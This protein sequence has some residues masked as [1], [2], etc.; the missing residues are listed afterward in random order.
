MMVLTAKETDDCGAIPGI[1]NSSPL[2]S[3]NKLKGS[4][5]EEKEADKIQFPD[6]VD[7]R[8]LFTLSYIWD[9]NEDIQ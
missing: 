4:G 2:K 9:S 7:Q 1:F 8:P 3:K 6:P 5:C